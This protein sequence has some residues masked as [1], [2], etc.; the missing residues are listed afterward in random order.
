MTRRATLT[1]FNLNT[2]TLEHNAI[3]TLLHINYDFD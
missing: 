2:L 3:H 1:D